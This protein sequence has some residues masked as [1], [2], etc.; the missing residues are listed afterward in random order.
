M[1]RLLQL[2]TDDHPSV[3]ALPGLGGHPFWSFKAR[4][5]DFMWLRDGLRE[6]LPAARVFTYGYDTRLQRSNSFQSLQDLGLRFGHALVSQIRAGRRVGGTITEIVIFANFLTGIT[7]HET[8]CVYW[9]KPWGSCGERGKY[10]TS[11]SMG[12]PPLTSQR[13]CASFPMAEVKRPI[14]SN[15]LKQYSS[16]APL[17]QAWIYLH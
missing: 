14:F 16:S 2:R 10:L 6:S 7:S 8:D 11:S 5:N 9:P 1:N 17:I 13:H 4:E 12:T 3:I 15:V